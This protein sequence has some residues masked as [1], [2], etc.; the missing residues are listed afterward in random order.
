MRTLFLTT[1]EV[2]MK[3]LQRAL[4]I[5]LIAVCL[6]P[7]YHGVEI[8][9]GHKVKPHSKP[10]MVSI[11][12]NKCPGKRYVHNCG[13]A[14]IST[15]WILT[16]AHCKTQDT[17][18]VV[19]GADSLSKT[20]KS[21]QKFQVK[22]QLPHPHFNTVTKENDIMLLELSSEAKLNNYV[23]LL[24]LPKN[25]NE[26]VKPGT[27]CT[28]AGWGAT[29]PSKPASDT[30]QEVE[31]SVIDRKK[32]KAMLHP[33]R[34]LVV[35]EDM[36]CAGDRKGRKGSYKGDSGGPLI[37]DKKCKGV[38]SYGPRDLSTKM[39]GVYTRISKKYLNWITNII[40]VETY[41]MTAGGF[42]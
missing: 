1:R 29:G 32:C 5:S 6:A 35:T 25:D 7:T 20:E 9:G 22:K 41:N 34:M 19:L 37:C 27:L 13:G 15:K 38:V 42:Y 8:I 40:G 28:V 2:T 31:I 12:V 3:S 16:A 26:D 14:L 39:P 10:Y 33:K 24:Q 23:Q 18:Q 17:L 4:F 30:L 11:Q 36:I 21:Q